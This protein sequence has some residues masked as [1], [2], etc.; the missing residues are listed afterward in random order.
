MKIEHIKKK[1]DEYFFLDVSQEEATRII[2]TLSSQML[3]K[4]PNV[5]REEFKDED[6]RYFTICVIQQDNA[7]YESCDHYESCKKDG[8]PLNCSKC[9]DFEVS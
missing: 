6:G 2:H 4:N 3:T 1:K 5:G 8:I 7:D 9:K